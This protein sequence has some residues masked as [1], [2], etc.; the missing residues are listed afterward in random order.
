M[1]DSIHLDLV[2]AADDEIDRQLAEASAEVPFEVITWDPTRTCPRGAF[3]MRA[4]QRGFRF[5]ASWDP[6]TSKYAKQW[7]R[8]DPND[9][10]QYQ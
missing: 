10:N 4:L 9:F 2:L 5:Q 7:V 3:E 6:E 8:N 1:S